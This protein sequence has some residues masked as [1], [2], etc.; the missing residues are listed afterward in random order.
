M[1]AET[2]NK[3]MRK[4]L[5]HE[6]EVYEDFIMGLGENQSL[7]DA[8]RRGISELSLLERDH[9]EVLT[10]MTGGE[11]GWLTDILRLENGVFCVDDQV[12]DSPPMQYLICIVV[13]GQC[14]TYSGVFEILQKVKGFNEAM[15]S[16]PY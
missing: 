5:F 1:T 12:W 10:E 7:Q 8:A 6:G 11:W 13:D 15:G 16:V 9:T 2:M 4:C 14:P 3:R